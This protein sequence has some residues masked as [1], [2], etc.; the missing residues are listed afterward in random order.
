MSRKFIIVA[1]WTV[2][3]GI[4][5]GGS[6]QLQPKIRA[7]DLA[8]EHLVPPIAAAYVGRFS[9]VA[10]SASVRAADDLPAICGR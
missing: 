1:A 2:F 9:A 3:A 10:D 4:E 7:R 6:W 8:V 5:R